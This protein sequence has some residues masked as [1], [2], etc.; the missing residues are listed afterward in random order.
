MN[1]LDRFLYSAGFFLSETFYRRRCISVC[2]ENLTR[3]VSFCSSHISCSHL[4]Y[5]YAQ[6]FPNSH[7]ISYHN[8]QLFFDYKFLFPL[9]PFSAFSDLVN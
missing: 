7:S 4:P 3:E 6:S 2:M 8:F 1:I 5:L 9:I